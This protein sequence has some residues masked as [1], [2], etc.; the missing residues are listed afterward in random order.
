VF[1][2]T[3][4]GAGRPLIPISRS[5]WSVRFSLRFK[6]VGGPSSLQLHSANPHDIL[7]PKKKEKSRGSSVS[8]KI[9]GR[10]Q[11]VAVTFVTFK[12]QGMLINNVKRNQPK[13][14]RNHKCSNNNNL[15]EP[16]F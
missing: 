1:C 8:K 3:G 7:F 4:L 12:V 6:K 2:E 5:L 11:E 13:L 10:Q 15:K 16:I 9:Q 14:K